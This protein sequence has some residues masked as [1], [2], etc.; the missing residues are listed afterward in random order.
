MGEYIYA[1]PTA[2]KGLTQD[3]LVMRSIAESQFR[4][5]HLTESRT[6]PRYGGC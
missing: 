2:L 1:N 3:S 6:T 4:I 5:A